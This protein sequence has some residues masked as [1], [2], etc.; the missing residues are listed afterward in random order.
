MEGREG[1][2]SRDHVFDL[3]QRNHVQEWGSRVPDRRI[4]VM[5]LR[6]MSFL[7]GGGADRRTHTDIKLIICGLDGR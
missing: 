4:L 1:A 5:C 2:R 6:P 3:R 7:R